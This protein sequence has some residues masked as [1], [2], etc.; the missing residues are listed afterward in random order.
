MSKSKNTDQTA[1]EVPDYE[2][3]STIEECEDLLEDHKNKLV[4]KDI[5]QENIKAEKRDYVSAI[6]EQLKELQE[7]RE[8]EIGVIGA[9]ED[10]KRFINGAKV[11][12]LRPTYKAPKAAATS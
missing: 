4:G 2:S 3:L 6:N 9:L 10:R 12:H 1:F 8:H 7:E 11:T 5:T